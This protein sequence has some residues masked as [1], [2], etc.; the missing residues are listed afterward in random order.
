M[1]KLSPFNRVT[2][3]V[4]QRQRIVILST[5]LLIIISGAIL[6]YLNTGNQKDAYA[7]LGNNMGFENYLT[8][9]TTIN[10]TWNSTSADKRGGTRAVLCSA[11]STEAILRNNNSTITIPSSGTNYIT[12]IAYAKAS[13]ITGRARLGVFNTNS[14]TESLAASTTSLTTS[15]Y[16]QLTF[17]LLATNGH[18]YV[19]VLCAQTS[20]GSAN[21]YYDDVIIYTS[22]ATTADITNPV[23]GQSFNATTSGTQIN[24]N[25]TNGTDAQSGIG[26]VM[27]LRTTG[28]TSASAALTN[29]LTYH[30]SN[31]S[32]GPTSVSGFNVVYNG[33]TV[34]SINNNPGSYNTY[35]YL[36]YTRDRAYNYSSTPIRLYVINGT[37]LS[38]SLS[39]NIS[40]DGLCIASTCTLNISNNRILTFENNAQ[41]NIFGYINSTGT[42]ISGSNVSINMK[43]GSTYEYS[44]ETQWNETTPILQANWESGS[45]CLITGLKAYSVSGFDQNF[46]H[47]VWNC[48]SQQFKFQFPVNRTING[49]LNIQNTSPGNSNRSFCFNGDCTIKGNLTYNN[50]TAT[51]ICNTNSKIIINGSSQQSITG[52]FFF[53]N[54]QVDNAAGVLLYDNQIINNTLF[55]TSGNLNMNSK[56]IQMVNGSLITRDGGSM[57]NGTLDIY[58]AWNA[59]NRYNLRYTV[60]CTSGVELISSSTR[61]NNLTI[62][63]PNNGAV[64]LNKHAVVNGTLTLTNGKIVSGSYEVRVIPTTA[65]SVSFT[66]NSFVEGFL[67]RN[68][69]NAGNVNYDFPVGFDDKLQLTTITAKALL[70]TSSIVASFSPNIT[71]AAPVP[72]TCKIG[73]SGITTLLDNGIWTIEPNVQPTGGNYD[74]TVKSQGYTNGY[75]NPMGYCIIKRNNSSSAWQS[76]G[77]HS[78]LTQSIDAGVVTVKRSSLTSF[79]DFG[80]GFGSGYNLPIS[81][82]SFEVK[83]H[84]TD[85]VK[86]TWTTAAELNNAYFSLERSVNGTDYEMIN[87]QE[88]AGTSTVPTSYQY[89]D[90]FP[91]S[92][93][94]Y[95]RL[96]QVDFDGTYTYG[97]VKQISLSQSVNN[98]NPLANLSVYPNPTTGIVNVSNVQLTQSPVIIKVYDIGGQFIKQ[99]TYNDG[100]N[101]QFNL[102]DQTPGVYMMIISDQNNN[103]FTK[104]IVLQP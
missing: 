84:E 64:T 7:A 50:N 96:K 53:E 79:S 29:Q 69:V 75:S 15:G 21:I 34:T 33:S 11:N 18:T 67:R 77:T 78:N 99:L 20:S 6:V 61:L 1:R 19:P 39:S 9:W 10:G 45:T 30:P 76:I 57:S 83:Q 46:H 41:G 90:K 81:L 23:K 92:G 85:K 17:N 86:I 62:D 49:N 91:V 43:N 104:Q 24:M 66:S 80:V 88:G 2:T 4:K 44:R 87:E 89:I 54:L 93:I 37:N 8:E 3:A 74:I 48:S 38:Q 51:V 98:N 63:V 14:S 55:L 27:V 82:S 71:G 40:L 59:A 32:I 58:E 36:I 95:Y 103:S 31:S 13:A 26:G 35:T 52:N 102:N 16:T 94:N 56:T 5:L 97:P 101:I 25:W 42:I 47:L 65:N 22:T 73:A 70:T 60:D 12:V 28:L 68:I 72:S 100:N